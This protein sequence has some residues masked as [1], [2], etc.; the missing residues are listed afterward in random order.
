MSTGDFIFNETVTGSISSTTGV[1]NTWDS[2]TGVL[3]IKVVTG[4]FEVGETIVGSESG[5]SRQLRIINTDDVVTPY[6]DN[7]IFES[8]ADSILDFSET[9]PFGTP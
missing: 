9:N 7:D 5:A 3:E 6:A 8:E 1:V 4:S 2:T